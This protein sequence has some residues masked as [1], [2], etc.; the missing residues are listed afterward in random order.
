M[1]KTKLISEYKKGILREKISDNKEYHLLEELIKNDL[2][3]NE[4]K[5]SSKQK[6]LEKK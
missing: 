5:T 2:N 6:V 4:E 1:H 3:K